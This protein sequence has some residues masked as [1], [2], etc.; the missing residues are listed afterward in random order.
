MGTTDFGLLDCW[1]RLR[2]NAFGSNVTL[3]AVKLS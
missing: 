1:E 3:V 2:M